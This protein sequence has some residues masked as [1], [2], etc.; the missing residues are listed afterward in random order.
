MKFEGSNRVFTLFMKKK[1]LFLL[2]IL[3]L[4]LHLSIFFLKSQNS[5]F[6]VNNKIF[7]NT[8]D[9]QWKK[10]NYTYL[11][12]QNHENII[13]KDKSKKQ[14]SDRNVSFEITRTKR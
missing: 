8:L 3:F 13:S 2:V 1:P 6:I 14:I 11:S 9:K 4:V 5:I 7:N 10:I 12:V